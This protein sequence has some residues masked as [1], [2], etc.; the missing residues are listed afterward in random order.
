MP[1]RQ[2]CTFR[3]DNLL[4]GID[5]RD[6]QEVMCYLD[7]TR[8]PLAPPVVEGLINLRGQ[9]VTA[10]NLRRKLELSPRSDEALPMSVVVRSEEGAISLLVDEIGDVIEVEDANFEPPP[11]TLQES[12]RSMIVG[13]YK[14]KD[15]LLHALDTAKAC[16]IEVAA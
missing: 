16:E 5:L 11:E 3:L 4:F 6:V 8:I 14:L 13:V 12:M 2:F 7:I 1:Q 15:R 9:I 10:L